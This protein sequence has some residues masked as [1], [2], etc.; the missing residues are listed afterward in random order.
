MPFRFLPK[1]RSKNNLSRIIFRMVIYFNQNFTKLWLL[2]K[3]DDTNYSWFSILLS[4]I[5]VLS[6]LLLLA[7][8]EI[9]WL[10]SSCVAVIN[11]SLLAYVLHSLIERRGLITN[12]CMYCFC[13]TVLKG[14][15]PF[16]RITRKFNNK[17]L[18]MKT[19]KNKWY[20][21]NVFQH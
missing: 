1:R 19:P 15:V 12:F 18:Y 4:W 11:W 21:V 9:N 20:S 2:S 14:Y 16:I 6:F 13:E 17:I 7:I 5:K 10:I 3:C 8:Y